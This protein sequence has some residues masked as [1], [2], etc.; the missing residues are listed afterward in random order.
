MSV[1]EH[2]WEKSVIIIDL[3]LL[4]FSIFHDFS[5]ITIKN[6]DEMTA[7]LTRS[8]ISD[9]ICFDQWSIV[10]ANEGEGIQ[11]CFRGGREL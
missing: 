9:S 1:G 6:P 3:S 7:L 8:I 2:F 5:A 11:E 4:I 10:V